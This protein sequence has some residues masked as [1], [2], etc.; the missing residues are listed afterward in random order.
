MTLHAQIQGFFFFSCL[1]Q[2]RAEHKGGAAA[3]LAGTLAVPRVQGHWT[4]SV[5]G[6]IA[7]PE[8]FFELFVAGNQKASL[9]GLSL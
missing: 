4:A 8:S 9:A 5:A 1:W 2:L 7:L 3:W 6:V